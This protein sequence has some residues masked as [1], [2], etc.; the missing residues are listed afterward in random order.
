MRDLS[1]YSITEFLLGSLYF[2]AALSSLIWAGHAWYLDEDYQAMQGAGFALALLSGCADPK[3]YF[4]DCYTFPFE[5]ARTA[6][7]ETPVTVIGA[8]LGSAM[9]LAGWLLERHAG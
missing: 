7:R 2:A 3:K 4:V 1:T 8:L 9:A 5:F 6:G